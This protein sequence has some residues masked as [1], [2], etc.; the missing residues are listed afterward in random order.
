MCKVVT[1]K[2]SQIGVYLDDKTTSGLFVGVEENKKA[3]GSGGASHLHANWQ[4]KWYKVV[5]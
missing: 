3:Q 1:L 2:V 4:W 5:V